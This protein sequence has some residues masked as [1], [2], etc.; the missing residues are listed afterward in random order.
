MAKATK[1]TKGSSTKKTLKKKTVTKKRVT[2]KKVVKQAP[3]KP[4][5]LVFK[6]ANDTYKGGGNSVKE[7]IEDV[8]KKLPPLSL[9]AKG[10]LTFTKG[11]YKVDKFMYPRQLRKLFGNEMNRILFGKVINT[12]LGFDMQGNPIKN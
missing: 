8:G 3:Q 9:T 7:A 1:K 11:K 5:T 2:K 6:I 12:G 10:T 4:Y